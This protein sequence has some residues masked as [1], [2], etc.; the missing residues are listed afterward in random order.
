MTKFQVKDLQLYLNN[1]LICSIGN[2]IEVALNDYVINKSIALESYISCYLQETGLKVTEIML[3]EQK[4]D[5]GWMFYCKPKED[6]ENGQ[7]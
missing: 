7:G 5:N 3:I 6:K 4:T 2:D 1:D